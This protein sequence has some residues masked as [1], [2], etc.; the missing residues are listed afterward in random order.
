MLISLRYV[1]TDPVWALGRSAPLNYLLNSAMYIII[2][3]ARLF[4]F[5]PTYFLFVYLFCLTY[6][7]PYLLFTARRNARHRIASAVL[8]T[9]IPSI[10]LKIAVNAVRLPKFEPV[11]GKSWS[12]R[13]MMIA[14]QP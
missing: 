7:L 11:N 9:P 14:R 13:K 1:E 10:R 2:L 3:F 8:A 5:P 6:V 12:P 4:G